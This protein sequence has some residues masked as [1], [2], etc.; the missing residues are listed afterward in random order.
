M[1]AERCSS[2]I[3]AAKILRFLS[4]IA[5]NGA[6]LHSWIEVLWNP[7]NYLSGILLDLDVYSPTNMANIDDLFSINR[8]GLSNSA[9][10]PVHIPERKI[11]NKPHRH[12]IRAWIV[13]QVG[14]HKSL[15]NH[16]WDSS[17]MPYMKS[18]E[19]N[20]SYSSYSPWAQN[21][22]YNLGVFLWCNKEII[23]PFYVGAYT[24]I[25]NFVI[26][27]HASGSLDKFNP[28]LQ[29]SNLLLFF[30]EAGTG[31][32]HNTSANLT[33]QGKNMIDPHQSMGH[34]GR[35]MTC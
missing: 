25:I 28:M 11:P 22:F 30:G 6:C 34:E 24:A 10:R 32:Q 29:H 19:S 2:M 31:K 4:G 27:S 1:L 23:L 15:T 12:F 7:E 20:P 16:Q 14:S 21:H 13:A 8:A 17:L 5:W 3:R 35:Q 18:K 33:E 9:T 26:G